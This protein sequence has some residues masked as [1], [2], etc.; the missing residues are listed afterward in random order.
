MKNLGIE[1]ISPVMKRYYKGSFVAY[2]TRIVKGNFLKN[3]VFLSYLM[4]C[5]WVA[6]I[7]DDTQWS[8][9]SQLMPQCDQSACHQCEGQGHM[10]RYCV[11]QGV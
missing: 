9:Q 1:I 3:S 8:N 2:G 11:A 10:E 7:Q 4:N 5:V 6:S